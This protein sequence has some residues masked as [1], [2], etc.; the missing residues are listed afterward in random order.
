MKQPGTPN[1]LPSAVMAV[2]LA[3]T[4]GVFAETGATV[5]WEGFFAG[6]YVSHNWGKLDTEG[7]TSHLSTDKD[8]V[9]MAGLLGGYRWQF[10]NDLVAGIAFELP[11]VSETEGAED[12]TWYPSPAFNPPAQYDY[13]IDWAFLIVGQLGRSYGRWLPYVEGGV[14]L[15]DATYRVKNVDQNDNYSPGSEQKTDN[16]HTIW[17]LGI[18]LDYK[19]DQNLVGG[20][21]LSYIESDQQNYKVNWLKP[22]PAYIGAKS[23]SAY[24]TLAYQFD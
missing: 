22:W 4:T 1:R 17:K 10:E 15:L 18:G 8:N 2:L 11:L 14:G 9:W 16:Q 21:K 7:D 24:A 23:V 5:D 20:L 19:F 12:V 3:S 6:A 13:E